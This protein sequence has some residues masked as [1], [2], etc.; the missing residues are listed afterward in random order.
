M[1]KHEIMIIDDEPANLAVL[2]R[3]L[4]PDTL[5]RAFR[6]AQE[7]LTALEG[8]A[9]PE[10]ILCDI[11]MPNVSGF[12]FADRVKNQ[13]QFRD[14]PII[15]ITA[16]DSSLDEEAGFRH[17]AV[18]YITK[19][20]S[21]AV[22]K[23]RVEAHLELKL[24][25]DRLKDQNVWLETEVQRRIRENQVIL[26]ATIGVVT[27]LVESRDLDT[28]NH[29]TR[30][31][32]YYRIIVEALRRKTGYAAILTDKFSD[33]LIK[34]SPL[35]D[36]G[37]V[38]IPD[39]ILNKPGRLSDEEFEIIKTHTVIGAQA[40][41]LALTSSNLGSELSEINLDSGLFFKEAIAI[42]RHHHERYDGAGYPD[43]LKGLDIP[44][45]ARIMSLVD[46]YDAL[47]TERVYK[48]AWSEEEAEHIILSQKGKQFDP[49]VV[50]AFENECARFREIHR[51]HPEKGD[52]HA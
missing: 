43:G 48:K 15:F 18:D 24:A 23:A 8:I 3:L 32:A 9:R 5:I 17:G 13:A 29:I 38:G 49:D 42:A 39:H 11:N 46:V 35:H 45:S 14:I 12:E 52:D 4:A 6:S 25:R 50:E 27:Q 47:T 30:T 1:K 41:N 34:A 22:V 19:P 44:L 21:P 36:I 26:D 28:G 10:L 51:G 40:L 37:K 33:I 2:N 31:K 7:A 16:L 20:F